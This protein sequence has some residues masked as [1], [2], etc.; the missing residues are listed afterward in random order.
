[1][2]KKFVSSKITYFTR[3]NV[4]AL[5]DWEAFKASHPQ[6][7][8]TSE[9]CW[10]LHDSM[11]ARKKSLSD[12]GVVK[13]MLDKAN[14]D[15]DKNSTGLIITSD[16]TGKTFLI[17]EVESDELLEQL[18]AAGATV[19]YIT[20]NVNYNTQAPDLYFRMYP[21]SYNAED[22]P[23]TDKRHVFDGKNIKAIYTNFYNYKTKNMNDLLYSIIRSFRMSLDIIK[24]DGII[25]NPPYSKI[26]ANITDSIRKV[27][28]FD[29]YINLLPAND[30]KRNNSK[31]LFNYQS[32]MISIKDGFADA[33]VTTHLANIH[34]TKVNNMSL[35]EFERS[36]Y[37]D[38]QLDKYFEETAKREKTWLFETSHGRD[39][40]IIDNE[41]AILIGS[42]EIP[43]GH[44]P[45]S[46]TI[47]TYK[48]NVE[49]SI[50]FNYLLE[51]HHDS[52]GAAIQYGYFEF[53]TPAEKQNFV[54]FI[55][56]NKGFKFIAKIFTA[57]SLDGRIAFSKWA[58]KVDWSRSWTV[59]EILA[60]Y[61]Y[62][63]DEIKEVMEDLKNFK[64]MED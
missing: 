27:I 36:Q 62:T 61:E 55:Y 14:I 11:L 32:D 9:I 33:A 60:D 57:L 17:V 35:D 4:G 28:D 59:E 26:G 45:Y 58:P 7:E 16:L 8:Y 44:L 15:Y 64:G 22:Y 10:D 23:A 49:K 5:A 54:D 39:S 18:E 13:Q 63:E 46:K 47:T 29:E 34:K 40:R 12:D 2:S 31:D 50:D 48:W 52:I 24:V 20:S 19:A 41:H 1:M 21:E 38:R 51:H 6:A 30:Y 42:R 3:D 37:I 53:S 56:S 43:N 25:A